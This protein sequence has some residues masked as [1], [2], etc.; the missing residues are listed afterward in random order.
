MPKPYKL[1]RPYPLPANAEIVDRDGRLCFQTKER[2]RTV[3]FPLTKAGD[4]YLKPSKRWY[5]D[6]RDVSGTVRR[7]KGY[8]DLKATEQLAAETERKASRVRS[9]F[10]DPGEEHAMRPLADHL[11]DYAAVLLA[12]GDTS[13]HCGQTV[14]RIAALFSGCGFAFPP[15]TDAAKAAAW[16]NAIR[17][18]GEPIRLPDRVDGFKPGE[19]AQLLGISGTAVGAALKRLGLAATVRATARPAACQGRR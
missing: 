9:G 7:V 11:K 18:D 16:L 3:Y 17:R 19:A 14:G 8:A 6:C 10:T 13:K 12:K 5:F 15:D 2:G 1:T 4:G